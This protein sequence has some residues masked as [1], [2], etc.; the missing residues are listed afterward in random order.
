MEKAGEKNGPSERLAD[1]QPAHV[2]FHFR[3]SAGKLARVRSACQPKGR[4]KVK[5]DGCDG[6]KKTDN[7]GRMI[8]IMRMT[9]RF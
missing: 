6:R 1:S 3:H 8:M 5:W 9:T 4:W 7:R 2:A